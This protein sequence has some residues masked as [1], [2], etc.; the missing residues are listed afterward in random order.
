MSRRFAFAGM[1]FAWLAGSDGVLAGDSVLDRYSLTAGSHTQWALPGK[2]LEISALAMTPDDR[3]LAVDD[4]RA[5]VFEIDYVSG[6]L[7][8]AFALDKPVLRGDFEGLAVLDQTV[9]LMTSDG[10]IYSAPEGGD[11]ERVEYERHKTGLGSECEFEGLAADRSAGRLLLLCKN[12]RKKAEIDTLSIYAWDAASEKLLPKDQIELPIRDISLALRLRRLHPSG[13]VVDA[14]SG[15][16]LLVAAREQVLIELEG[17]GKFVGAR[18][19]ELPRRHPQAEGIE[20]AP[21]GRLILADEGGKSRARLSLY[22]PG[23]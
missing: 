12:V 2:L 15:N 6:G 19:L 21:D 14:E 16:L 4:E 13:I 18:R 20:L 11:G 3:L 7:I 23:R 1:L 10:D 9:Y 5:V 8:K 17:D 22:D